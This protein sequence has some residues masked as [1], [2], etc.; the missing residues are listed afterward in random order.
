MDISSYDY[1][2]K[3]LS[4]YVE[5][6]RKKLMLSKRNDFSSNEEPGQPLD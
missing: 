5:G 4:K 3:H 2:K 6:E 1:V